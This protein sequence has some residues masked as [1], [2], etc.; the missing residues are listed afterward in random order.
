MKTYK[1]KLWQSYNWLRLLGIIF[2]N[3]FSLLRIRIRKLSREFLRHCISNNNANPR[4][5]LPN[6]Y[7]ARSN[8]NILMFIV[9]AVTKPFQF[10]SWI[11]ITIHCKTWLQLNFFISKRACNLNKAILPNWLVKLNW[12]QEQESHVMMLLW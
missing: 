9:Y 8:R 1:K 10:P 7:L 2:L 11:Y 12:Q 4:W 6:S 5:K 3:I